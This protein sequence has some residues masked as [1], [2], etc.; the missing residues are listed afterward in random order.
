MNK[1]TNLILGLVIAVAAIAF[2][3]PAEAALFS[4]N[5]GG[6][7]TERLQKIDNPPGTLLASNSTTAQ[8]DFKA[9]PVNDYRIVDLSGALSL[10]LTNIMP[11]RVARVSIDTDGS[12]RAISILTNGMP[13]QTE[14]LYSYNNV[15]T[16]G[17]SAFTVTNRTLCT[18]TV[19]QG[20]NIVWVNFHHAR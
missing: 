11:G 12:A 18:I 3:P 13:A 10:Q 4:S 19:D 16:N 14:I 5:N 20:T 6:S 8:I 7:V 17:S 15:N 2:S 1:R 9:A